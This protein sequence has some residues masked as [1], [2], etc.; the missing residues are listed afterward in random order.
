MSPSALT[1]QSF[2]V[3]QNKHVRFLLWLPLPL[4]SPQELL[5][6]GGG[7]GLGG[8]GD[9]LR[10]MSL[11]HRRPARRGN[12]QLTSSLCGAPGLPPSGRRCASATAWPCGLCWGFQQPRV[13]VCVYECVSVSVCM[14]V[15][16]SVCVHAVAGSP[17]PSVAP[18]SLGKPGPALC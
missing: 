14:S 2:Q 8:P 11:S 3:F 18:T 1:K 7:K 6:G 10:K 16:V 17:S 12:P 4:R 5:E 9:P 13:C 15:C